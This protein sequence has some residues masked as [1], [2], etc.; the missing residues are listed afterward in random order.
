MPRPPWPR[1]KH[2]DGLLAVGVDLQR[3]HRPADV[4]RG[5]RHQGREFGLRRHR[6][7]RREIGRERLGVERF[8]A[9]F[10]HEALVEIADLPRCRSA[11]AGCAGLD[12]RAQLLLREVVDI[13]PGARA[14]LIGRDLGLGQPTPVGVGEEIIAGPDVRIPG[15][16][17]H[18]PAP[19]A[20]WR[21][22]LAGCRRRDG[23]RG[24]SRSQN[25]GQC[26]GT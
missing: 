20:L 14:G 4:R 18:A 9:G 5:L 13:A 23:G 8:D 22:R 7:D 19:E 17:I 21:G 6:R 11:G 1:Y 26:R 10:V 16:E 12:Q 2:R 15:R 25:R 24:R 3:K